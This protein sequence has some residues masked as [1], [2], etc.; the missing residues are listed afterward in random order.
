ML[1]AFKS[2][3]KKHPSLAKNVS[4]DQT[5]QDFYNLYALYGEDSNVWN[6]Y[7][8]DEQNNKTKPAISERGESSVGGFSLKNILNIFQGM[9]V[10]ELQ[11]GIVSL[12]KGLGYISTMFAKEETPTR[13]SSYEPRPIH[14]YFDD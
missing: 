3:V 7:F 5:W 9:D 8:T 12:Q 14:K 10:N 11:K 13:Q 6:Q 4:K 2:F 1:D